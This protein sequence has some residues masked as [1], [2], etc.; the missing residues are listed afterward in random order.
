MKTVASTVVV[1]ALFATVGAT[2]TWAQH[3]GQPPVRA[4]E[5]KWA[6]F[7]A[8]PKG[9]QVAVIEGP[10]N[11]AVPFTVRLKFPD[12]YR[13]PAHT[14]PSAERLTV[15][16]GTFHIG[17]GE[18]FDRSATQPLRVGDMIIL[19]P[20]MPHFAWTETETVVQLHGTGPSGIKYVNAAED[21]RAP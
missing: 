1:L 15:L 13:I 4:A 10:T 3:A 2:A 20:G 6:P 21:P 12:G 11:Q 5:L 9:A 19:Q 17:M 8:L 18:K 14:H 16:S 7:P